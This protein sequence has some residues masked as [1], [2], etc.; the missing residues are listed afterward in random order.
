LL[1]AA[2]H[3]GRHIPTETFVSAYGLLK[4]D[5]NNT[6]NVYLA[7][8]RLD[9]HTARASGLRDPLTGQV[10]SDQ[11][12]RWWLE[13]TSAGEAGDHQAEAFARARD[14]PRTSRDP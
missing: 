7:A 3:L 1:H 14:L 11:G 5:P 10:W 2:S 13:A 9:P 4:L 12:R 6:F 8:T